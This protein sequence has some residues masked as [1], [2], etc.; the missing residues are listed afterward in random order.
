[1]LNPLLQPG[2]KLDIKIVG[3]GGV[4]SYLC[5][6]S[7]LALLTQKFPNSCITVLDKD[8]LE[9]RNFSRQD[10]AI[11]SN[12]NKA[13][14]LVEKLTKD[15]R[16]GNLTFKAVRDWLSPENV[17]SQI[18]DGCIVMC[19][20]DGNS[21]KKLLSDRLEDLNEGTLIVGANGE[22]TTTTLVYLRRYGK[23]LNKP[24]TYGR[25][26]ISNP[27]DRP[28]WEMSCEE[29]AITGNAQTAFANED[30]AIQMK[31]FF[32]LLTRVDQ[33]SY[34]EVRSNVLANTRYTLANKL[35]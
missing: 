30:V 10:F 33:L 25:P 11:D 6:H 19:C 26:E 5:N 22:Y 14:A 32:H 21:I 7:W 29:A 13:A 8:N 24:L 15:P 23:D 31:N 16:Y 27:Q 34:D 28:A 4:A 1:M 18:L 20:A 35:R 12:G 9:E 2:T 3:A 17:E